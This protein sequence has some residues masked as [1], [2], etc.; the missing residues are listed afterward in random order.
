MG[1]NL[2][3]HWN[4]VEKTINANFDNK[5]IY[6]N[7][8]DNIATIVAYTDNMSELGRQTW[9]MPTDYTNTYPLFLFTLNNQGSAGSSCYCSGYRLY[10][11]KI[12]SANGNTLLRN[13]I[14]CKNASNVAG[15]WEDVSQTFLQSA[16]SSYSFIAGPEIV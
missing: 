6:L 14:P 9:T 1:S 5:I 13:Y 8:L 15:V 16:T 3:I 10:Y 7:N 11:L 2:V 12:Y 4:E